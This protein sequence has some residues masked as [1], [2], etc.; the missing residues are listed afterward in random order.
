MVPLGTMKASPQGAGF[1]VRSSHVY[2][3]RV[4][5][6]FSNRDLSSTSERLPR[7]ISI[8]C[9]VLEVFWTILANNSKESFS[10]L[11]LGFLLDS[12]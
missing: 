1:Q 5:G 6:V 8:A 11:V 12:L 7:A 3:P 10:Y 9:N 2:V 4:H